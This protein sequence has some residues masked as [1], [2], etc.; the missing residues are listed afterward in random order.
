MAIGSGARRVRGVGTALALG[1]AGGAGAK[2]VEVLLERGPTTNHPLYAWT[3]EDV[4]VRDLLHE[5]LFEPDGAGGWRSDVVSD[6]AVAGAQV[7]VTLV[8]RDWSDGKPFEPADVCATIARVK[9]TDRPTPFTAMANAAVASCVVGGK[10]ATDKAVITLTAPR[11]EPRAVLAFPL[12]PEHAPDWAGAGPQNTIEAVGLGRY[13]LDPKHSTPTALS[14]AQ[15]GDTAPWKKLTLAVVPDPAKALADGRG[16]GA[17]F[18]DPEDLA[19]ARGAAGVELRLER[20]TGVWALMVNTHRGPLADPEVRAALDRMIDRDALAGG[21]L[22]RDPELASQPWTPVS[23]PFPPKSPLASGGVPVTLREPEAARMG[24]E[25]AGLVQG[26]DGWTWGGAPWRLKVAIPADL[27][28]DP[29]RLRVAL[30]Q[31]LTGIKI[32]VVALSSTQWWYSLLSGGH[33]D[34][35]DLALMPVELGAVPATFHSRTATA[36]WSNPF[37]WSDPDVD[38]WLEALEAGKLDPEQAHQMHAAIADLH[39]ALFLWAMEGRSA[40]RGDVTLP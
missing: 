36:G 37:G 7:T 33:S 39:P 35:S 3:R 11:A 40:W 8:K 38:R 4:F 26:P 22:G 21:V 16:V 20:P 31:Q 1:W 12:V 9:A 29:E 28:P 5:S 15:V 32:E 19:A 13:A 2:P 14:L 24:L 18:V 27:G 17:P 25:A 30:E 6:V 10:G 34:A 23:G